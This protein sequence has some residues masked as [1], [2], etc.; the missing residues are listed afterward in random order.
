MKEIIDKGKLIRY[1]ILLMNPIKKTQKDNE[2]N[3]TQ[4]GTESYDLATQN[5]EQLEETLKF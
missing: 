4:K 5:S 1:S 3:K 2:K